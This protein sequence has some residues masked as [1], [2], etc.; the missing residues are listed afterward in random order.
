MP[1]ATR[2]S[3][4]MKM[5]SENYSDEEMAAMLVN[6]LIAA[7][8]AVTSTLAQILQEFAYNPSVRNAALREAINQEQEILSGET[9]GLDYITNCALEGL[10]LFA[11]ATLVKRQAR[12]DT[13]VNNILIPE[14][15][16]S[17]TLYFVDSPKR[18]KHVPK[19]KAI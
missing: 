11:P 2:T 8:E 12:K 3:L 9:G 1:P 16:N 19:F 17:R 15:D 13:I 14:G 10:R 7:E 18:R 5:V 4:L 6:V